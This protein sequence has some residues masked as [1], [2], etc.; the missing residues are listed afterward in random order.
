M[1]L[2]TCMASV[3]TADYIQTSALLRCNIPDYR[4][5]GQMMASIQPVC[6]AHAAKLVNADS[7]GCCKT[8]KL[9]SKMIFTEHLRA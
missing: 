2:H 4:Y 1:C 8:A 7:H 9:L 3:D 6:L 5:F